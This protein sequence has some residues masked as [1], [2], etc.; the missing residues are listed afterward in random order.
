MMLKAHFWGNNPQPFMDLR[1]KQTFA[2]PVCPLYPLPVPHLVVK[3]DDPVCQSVPAPTGP[4]IVM[5]SAPLSA[6]I[7]NDDT[8]V[9]PLENVHVPQAAKWAPKKDLPNLQ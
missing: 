6:G 2:Q 8:A 4:L 7:L 9:Q 5:S 1:L 3:S